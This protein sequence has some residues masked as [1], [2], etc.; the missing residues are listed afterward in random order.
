MK[1]KNPATVVL[2]H[3]EKL[4]HLIPP[5]LALEPEA[6]EGLE[7]T[8]SAALNRVKAIRSGRISTEE[9]APR[10]PSEEQLIAAMADCWPPTPEQIAE[11]ERFNKGPTRSDKRRFAELTRRRA[12]LEKKLQGVEAELREIRPLLDEG[13]MRSEKQRNKS[14]V[15]DDVVRR[16]ARRGLTPGEISHSLRDMFEYRAHTTGADSATREYEARFGRLEDIDDPGMA[17][18]SL[19][20]KAINARLHRLRIKGFNQ[21]V[22]PTTRNRRK[23]T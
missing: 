5:N 1:T 17:S 4:L 22:S 12:L 3:A 14:L 2:R 9:N 16:L 19:S 20:E 21:P 23:K 10:P 13:T 7:M 11:M 6:F 8:L 18:D 15:L